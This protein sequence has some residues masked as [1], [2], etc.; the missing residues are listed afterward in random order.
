MFHHALQQITTIICL[1]MQWQHILWGQIWKERKSLSI[2][3]SSWTCQ[4]EI[5]QFKLGHTE[6]SRIQTPFQNNAAANGA[7]HSGV[8][9]TDTFLLG[10]WSAGSV[11]TR[12]CCCV[13]VKE[14]N[15]PKHREVKTVH[16]N[17]KTNAQAKAQSALHNNWLKYTEI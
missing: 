6:Q 16:A 10:P 5:S 3:I 14:Y 2:Y 4:R 17:K 1:S 12:W 7:K 11:L 15:H 13:C 8:R 9:V